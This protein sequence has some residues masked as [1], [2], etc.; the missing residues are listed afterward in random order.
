MFTDLVD[1][2]SLS[3]RDEGKTLAILGE[4]RAIVRPLLSEFGGREVKT[5]GDGFLVEF[6]SALNATLCA[7]EIQARSQAWRRDAGGDRPFVRI[8]V[9]VG[10]VVHD[11]DDILGDAVNLASRIE[12]LAEPGGICV[13]GAIYEQVVNKVPHKFDRLPTP[14]LKGVHSPLEVFRLVRA[15]AETGPAHRLPPAYRVAVLPLSSR[16]PDPHDEY[17][18]DGL[19]D[20]LIHGLSQLGGLRVIAR[21][22]V[23]HYR[24][25]AKPLP[26]VGFELN[27]QS[28]IEGS[29]RRAG[30]RL[31]VTI[32]LIDVP[33]QTPVWA[34]QYDR[35]LDDVFAIQSDIAL[36]VAE[37][38]RVTVAS[39]EGE[40]LQARPTVSTA[41]YLAY[42]QGRT[43]LR[44]LTLEG[45]EK[46]VARFE[47]AV[48]L[49]PGNSRACAGLADATYQRAL[50]GEGTFSDVIE[51]LGRS[52]D[53]ARRSI[54]L[55]AN[56]A[57]AHTS[58]GH[59]LD[60][61]M[62]FEAAEGELRTAIALNPAYA[63][64]HR[65]YGRLLTE[66]GRLDE[67]LEELRLAEEADPL[68]PDIQSV[69][70]R[71]LFALGRLDEA[72]A[73]MH[74]L[75]ELEPDGMR[76]HFARLELAL[77]ESDRPT[78]LQEAEW[79]SV[80]GPYGSPAE[81]AAYWK[82]VYYA[83]TGDVERARRSIDVLREASEA[84]DGTL[85]EWATEQM[86]EIYALLGDLDACFRL[87]DAALASRALALEHWW[88]GASFAGVR[89]DPRFTAFLG[90]A[91][92]TASLRGGTGA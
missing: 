30:N 17:L 88:L 72:R 61:L 12:P 71:T 33:S 7:V 52:R 65:W 24:H 62:E 15:G 49:D 89:S 35:E 74:R 28:V 42:L 69:L 59:F 21:T 66:K 36:H 18:A 64:A 54:A 19:T 44:S 75:S 45:S 8:S 87:L 77:L 46:A 79:F 43:Q 26:Q 86:A 63:P 4:H 25:L 70:A 68:S 9:H 67:A 85:R 73:K 82:G 16:S 90:K 60:E 58:L 50:L 27:V 37:T 22:S 48:R 14:V 53:L 91:G 29:V 39:A 56:A 20:E 47:E 6:D 80:H 76:L 84:K 32:Q 10:D 1:Y 83:V 55:E 78:H 3:Q 51:A 41:S 23:D 5:T 81:R 40:R 2:T 31:R 11:G 57:E 34:Q 38:L 92:L 13:S